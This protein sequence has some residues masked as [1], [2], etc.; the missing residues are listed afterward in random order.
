[1]NRFLKGE[2]YGDGNGNPIALGEAF[3][4]GEWLFSHTANYK[5]SLAI[6]LSG[7]QSDNV[8]FQ[9]EWSDDDGETSY[10]LDSRS[11]LG[12]GLWDVDGRFYTISGT[13]GTHSVSICLSPSQ[14]F[15]VNIARTGGD[16]GSLALVKATA[17]RPDT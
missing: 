15:R 2:I 4:Q 9:V 8:F 10:P 1:M 12:S 14:L 3:A 6:T 11:Y 17:F 13:I 7:T 16:S 5:I